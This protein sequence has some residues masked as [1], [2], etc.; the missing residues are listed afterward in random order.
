MIHDSHLNASRQS[1]ILATQLLDVAALLP[2]M[3]VQRRPQ[4]AEL[5]TNIRAPTTLLVVVLLQLLHVGLW[6]QD[7][8]LIRNLGITM[9][10]K[11]G[12]VLNT[13]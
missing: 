3:Q 7:Q 1:L 6:K 8:Q 9:L 12:L 13:S 5:L 2:Q 11:N 4:R 10:S